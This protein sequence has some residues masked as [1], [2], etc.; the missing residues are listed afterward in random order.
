M[1]RE[2][3]P[4]TRSFRARSGAASHAGLCLTTCLVLVLAGGCTGAPAS[5]GSAAG[6]TPA[7][8]SSPAQIATTQSATGAAPPSTLDAA[9]VQRQVDL[10]LSPGGRYDELIRAILVLVDGE[11]IVEHYGKN[12]SPQTTSDIFSV[13]KSVMSMLIG[14]A[15]GDG[16]IGS[17][18]Q[19]LGELLP[20]Y[21][22]VMAP[23]VADITLRQVLTMTGGIVDDTHQIGAS[24]LPDDWI[25]AIVSTPLQSPPGTS[26]AYSSF[27]SQLLSA[28]LVQATGRSVLDYAREKLLG[29]LGISTEPAAQPT[30]TE[31]L[32]APG[33]GLSG[34]VWPVDPKG[35]NTGFAYLHLT[36]P[37]MAKLGQLFLDGGQWQ[38]RQVVPAAWVKEST[39]HLVDSDSTTMPGYGYQWW[40]GAADGHDAFAAFGYAGQ[41]VEVVPDLKL[42]VVVSSSDGNA[43]FNADSFAQAVSHQIAPAVAG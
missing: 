31:L 41:L 3:Q 22:A 20:S 12:G 24:A 27:G 17:V 23:G 6:P 26:F 30:A 11:P 16:Q 7:L 2:E 43:S 35:N 8:E 32:G 34:F 14:I 40:V 33:D 4:M 13:T 1:T 18:D 37:D 21:A 42:V 5:S 29:P 19:T 38:G 9:E 39:S 10:F 15:I 25:S 36:P 28:I